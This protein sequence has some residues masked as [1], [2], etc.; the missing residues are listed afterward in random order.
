[1]YDTL[2]DIGMIAAFAAFIGILLYEIT[3]HA[4]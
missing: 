1:M 2:Q 3:E 4:S